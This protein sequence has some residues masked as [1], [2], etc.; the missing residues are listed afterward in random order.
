MER[1]QQIESIFQEA[2]ER[3][4]AERNAW[5]RKPAR[6][7]PIYGVKSPFCSRTTRRPPIS[8]LGPRL[9]RHN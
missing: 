4:P 7:T 6:T 1:W 5:L 9:R 3:D 8:S 2:L